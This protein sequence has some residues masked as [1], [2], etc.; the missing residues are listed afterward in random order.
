LIFDND[1]TFSREVSASIDSL[2]IM[3]KRTASRSPWQN[4]TAERWVGS[5]KRK[6]ID[7]AIV[8]NQQHLRWLIRDYVHYYNEGRVHTSLQNWSEGRAVEIRPSSRAKVVGLPH[9]GGLHHRYAWKDAASDFPSQP[10]WCC[11]SILRTRSGRGAQV[12][13][14][15]LGKEVPWER[16]V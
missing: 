1:T 3:P 14:P 9:V 16:D 12:I 6:L 4:G 5:C 7:H 8:L 13:A 2:G 11:G 15:S 10:I